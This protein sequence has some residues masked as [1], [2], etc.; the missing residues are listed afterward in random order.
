VATDLD[1][2]RCWD[3]GGESIDRY[4]VVWP[5]GNYLAMDDNP[6][7]PTG[8][9]QHGEGAQYDPEVSKL[10]GGGVKSYLGRML[11]FQELP[12]ECRKLVL[13]DLKAEAEAEA[14]LEAR[15]GRGE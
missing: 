1:E 6:C 15:K 3:N 10:P 8:F 12:A 13:S 14:E 9:G 5:D 4:T 7:W 2:L 11:S